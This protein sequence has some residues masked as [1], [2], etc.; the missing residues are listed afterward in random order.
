ML[1]GWGGV[2]MLTAGVICMAGVLP[3]DLLATPRVLYAMGRDG[4]LPAPLGTLHP[5]FSTPSAAIITYCAVCLLLALSGT[6]KALAILAAAGTL[7][8]YFLTAASVLVLRR[9]DANIGKPPFVIPG[10][11]VVPVVACVT[12]LAVLSTLAWR[13]LAAM[14]ILVVVAAIPFAWKAIRGGSEVQRE[15]A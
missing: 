10:G 6:F 12:I 9:R 13:E 14:G 7:I 4:L 8:M 2:L 11:P 1:G 3:G 15:G 5:R